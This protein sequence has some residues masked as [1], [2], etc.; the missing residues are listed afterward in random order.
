MITKFTAYIK[1]QKLF[2]PADKLLVA[3]SGGADSITLCHLLKEANYTFSVAH[4]NFSLRDEE[5]DGDENFVKDYC[6]KNKIPFFN[7]AF[8]TLEYAQKKGI[9]IQ[10]A[11]RELRY[12]WF[13]ELIEKHNFDYLLTAHHANDNI[14]TFFINLLRGSGINGLKAIVPKKDK[15]VRPLLFA[16]RV[17]IESY[18]AKS[19][20]LFREDSSNKE[21]KYL[22]NQLR[23]QI[24][25]A[26]KKLN[27]S[28][29]KTISNEIEILQETNLILQKE[30]EKQRKKLLIKESAT[31]KID[32]K[33]LKKVTAS[34]L[35]LFELISEFNFNSSQVNDVYEALQGQPGKVFTSTT[36]TLIKDRDFLF[37]KKRDGKSIEEFLIKETDSEITNPIKLTIS[38]IDGNIDT[39]SKKDFSANK[40]FIDADKLNFPLLVNHWQIGDKFKPLGMIGFKKVSDFFTSE[41]ATH[42]DKQTQYIIRCQADIVWLVGKRTDDRFKVTKSTKK[43]CLLTF[44]VI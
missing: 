33:K 23:L 2:K 32:I 28:F 17:E 30:V 31:F 29:E 42:F 36:H 22:R 11:A 35:I 25:P 38:F 41:K 43:I 39:I 40:A 26:F 19:K 44:S 9:S 27:P 37:V 4:C 15:I 6:K 8:N 12:N 21:E 10:M 13:N 5:S 7:K 1:K 16:T 14:E 24:I 20:I 3:V 34:K 18:I